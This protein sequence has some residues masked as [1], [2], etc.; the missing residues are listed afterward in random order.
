VEQKSKEQTSKGRWKL[1]AVLMVCASPLI[2]S[3]FTYY[4][5]K[6]EG[7][8]NYGDLIDPR[9]HPIPDLKALTLDGK[10][11]GLDAYKGKWIMLRVAPSECAKPCQDQ[12]FFMRQMRIMQ[13][14][15]QDRV[16]RVWLTTDMEPLDIPLLKQ[17]DGMHVLRA[18]PEALKRWLPLEPGMQLEEH[19]FLIDPLGN[20]MMRFP[21]DPDPSKVKKD[22]GKLLKASAIG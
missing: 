21:K 10:P 11:S 15:N 6:P 1:L 17:F 20:L 3:Y 12:V 2:A 4:V 9:K 19:L 5:V 14:K 7:R 22:L 16:E 8:T 18:D 13:G